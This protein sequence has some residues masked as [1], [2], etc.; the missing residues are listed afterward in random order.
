[1]AKNNKQQ[2]G[3][4]Q[5]KALLKEIESKLTETV[6][7]YHQK[8]SSKKL[9]KKIHKAGKLLAESVTKEKITVVHKEKSKT[10]KKEKK[11]NET[12]VV[13]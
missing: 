3:K 2:P 6:K 10:P 12:E 4:S 7:G 1:M 8:I 11:V 13:S 5:K 9:G